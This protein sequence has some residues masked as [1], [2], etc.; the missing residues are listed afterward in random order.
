MTAGDVYR[1]KAA[2]VN[3]RAEQEGSTLLRTEL[4]K[5]ALAYLLLAQQADSNARNDV[6]YETPPD[7]QQQQQKQLKPGAKKD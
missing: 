4:K 7:A 1:I 5:L 3:E 6:V 2:E